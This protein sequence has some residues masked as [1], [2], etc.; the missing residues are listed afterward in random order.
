MGVRVRNSVFS[1]GS[2][3][4]E[5]NTIVWAAVEMADVNEVAVSLIT[6][7]YAAF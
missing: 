5:F 7:Q 6:R 3:S 1:R 2:G 4:C